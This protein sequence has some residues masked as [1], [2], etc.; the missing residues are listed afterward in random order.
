MRRF[1]SPQADAAVDSPITIARVRAAGVGSAEFF[2]GDPRLA[3]ALAKSRL[4]KLSPA[5]Q[6]TL[7]VAS[8]PWSMPAATR[9][10][11]EGQPAMIGLVLDGFC[12]VYRTAPD[13]REVTFHYARAGNILGLG[14][15]FIGPPPSSF[16]AITDLE[17]LP[18]S[19]AAFREVISQHNALVIQIAAEEMTSHLYEIIAEL[20]AHVF[21]SLGERVGHHLLELAI[22]DQTSG[23]LTTR[24]TRQDLA[25]ATASARESVSRALRRLAEQGAIRLGP[26][27]IDILRPEALCPHSL[28]I[29]RARVA[30]A[31]SAG[32]PGAG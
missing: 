20:T 7:L 29:G 16:Q 19:T 18:L 1:R 5:V 23:T 30:E 9:F 2:K 32:A 4:G 3:A 17:I 22:A 25:N 10:Y 14:M 6:A 21:E 11:R 8:S 28:E 24:A 12:R 26:R 27:R 13:G 31:I 15:L